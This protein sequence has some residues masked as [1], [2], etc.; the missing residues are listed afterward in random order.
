MSTNISRWIWY[1]LAVAFFVLVISILYPG[2]IF[3]RNIRIAC[4]YICVYVV[5]DSL[6]LAVLLSILRKF[7]MVISKKFISYLAAVVVGSIFINFM[8]FTMYKLLT[9]KMH[10]VA[11][12]HLLLYILISFIPYAFLNY[13]LSKRIFVIKI[14]EACIIGIIMGLVNAF[15]SMPPVY[16]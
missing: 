9:D 3:S 5:I 6:L 7:N 11:S 10:A 15:V 8:L 12:A 16:H 13:A 14:Y 4:T 1:C 2:I